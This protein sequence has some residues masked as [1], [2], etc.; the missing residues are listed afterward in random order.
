MCDSD[1]NYV[2]GH[3]SVN[4]W[5]IFY[6]NHHCRQILFERLF[7]PDF[8]RLVSLR[9][10]FGATPDRRNSL[11]MTFGALFVRRILHQNTFG[12]TFSSRNYFIKAFGAMSVHQVLLRNTLGDDFNRQTLLRKT[13]GVNA[14]G[15]MML[16]KCFGYLYD[17]KFIKFQ[18]GFIQEKCKRFHFCN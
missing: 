2:K 17:E 16:R 18:F 7:G 9:K 4:G 11:L 12:A 14:D 8:D 10:R 1:L 5:A 3:G 6:K 15:Q 13:V